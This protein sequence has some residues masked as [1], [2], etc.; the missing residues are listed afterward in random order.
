MRVRWTSLA[1]RDF[2]KAQDYIAKE[3][4]VAATTIARR[5][6]VA[7]SKLSENPKIGR[8]GHVEDTREL[9][10]SRTPYL[11]V[12]RIQSGEIELLRVWHGRQNWKQ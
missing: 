1:L 10:V 2:V 3:N 9:I 8:L 6:S 4:P 7:A 5:V 12:Y 11:I